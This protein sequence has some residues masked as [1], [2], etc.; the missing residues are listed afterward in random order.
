MIMSTKQ[1]DLH[2]CP[3]CRC[4]Q[5]HVGDTWLCTLCDRDAYEDIKWCEKWKLK[6][7]Y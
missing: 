2:I 5:I 4:K 1:K 3:I 7:M 6:N